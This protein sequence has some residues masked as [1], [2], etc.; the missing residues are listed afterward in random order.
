MK[1]IATIELLASS[2]WLFLI[3]WQRGIF[4]FRQSSSIFSIQSLYDMYIKM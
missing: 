3:D 2:C 1:D 4:F